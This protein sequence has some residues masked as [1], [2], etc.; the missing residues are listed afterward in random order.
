MV[1]LVEVN[2]RPCVKL[3][4]DF[5]KATFPGKK[6]VYRLYDKNNIALVDLLTKHD[7][8]EPQTSEKFLCQHPFIVIRF[9]STKKN[10]LSILKVNY[11]SFK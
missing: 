6:N 10:L 8:A 2:G 5:Q 1:K 9:V 3:S 11:I 7:E 4:E